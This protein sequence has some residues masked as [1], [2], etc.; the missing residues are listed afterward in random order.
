MLLYL[1]VFMAILGMGVYAFQ[2]W[3]AQVGPEQTRRVVKQTAL[4]LLVIGALFLV[5]RSGSALLAVAALLIPFF[6]RLLPLLR[7]PLAWQ[8]LAPWLYRKAA[9]ASATSQRD[10]SAEANDHSRSTVTTRFFTMHLDHSSGGL[11]GRVRE[12]RF[13]ERRITDL[14]LRELLELHRECCVDPQ[15]V[16]VLETY[17]DRVHPDWRQRAD[18]DENAARGAYGSGEMGVAEAYEVLGLRTGATRE[19]IIAAH[20]QLM[21]KFHPD[22]GG[23][24][25][26]AG[27]IN[28]A[29]RVLLETF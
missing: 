3:S 17:L 13:R 1:V 15:S 25:Y 21:Q 6:K 2:R 16:A 11:D 7:S 24:D 20:R 12:G 18:E 14:S 23:T 9:R 19:E 28:E 4:V 27:R 22:H 8:F 26:L 5:I 29:R 10:S